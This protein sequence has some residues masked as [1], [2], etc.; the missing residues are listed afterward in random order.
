MSKS[1][2]KKSISFLLA[3]VLSVSA[4]FAVPVTN[5]SAVEIPNYNYTTLK[6]VT[7]NPNGVSHTINVD[8]ESILTVDVATATVHPD[9]RY[10]TTYIQV[11]NYYNTKI[12]DYNIYNRD[13]A[14]EQFK[15]KL[16]KGTYTLKISYSSYSNS[17]ATLA[18]NY[19]VKPV[20]TKIV[21][22]GKKSHIYLDK[23][24]KT[25]LSL[26]KTS[27]VTLY[28]TFPVEADGDTTNL[29]LIV[30][31]S[32]GTKV[33]EEYINAKD[34]LYSKKMEFKKE[35]V[36]AKGKYTVNFQMHSEPLYLNKHPYTST[37]SISTKDLPSNYVPTPK[38]TAKKTKWTDYSCYLTLS[39]ADNAKYDGIEVWRKQNGGS[40]KLLDAENNTYSRKIAFSSY[41]IRGD[42]NYYY[43]R[44]YKNGIGTKIYSK[45]SNVVSMKYL[46]KPKVSLGTSGVNLTFDVS[47]RSQGATG[48]EIWRSTKKNS[49]YKKYATTSKN[50]GF[51][52][53][54]KKEKTAY[55]YKVRAYKKAGSE[56]MYS[57]FTTPTKVMPIGKPN[58]IN[59]YS[60]KKQADIYYGSVKGAKGYEIWRSTKKTSGFKKIKTTNKT[61][62]TNKWLASKKTYY[63]KVRAYKYVG[64]TKVY[65]NYTSVKSVKTR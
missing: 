37:F 4:F 65:S 27:V 35:Y 14:I 5:V 8:K 48:Y 1:I 19:S 38:V 34:E 43:I 22:A 3:M 23:D 50:Y 58:H 11:F 51:T 24:N 57:S 36:L 13:G 7:A 55:Y 54:L 21:N 30:L 62:Y 47:T 53:S 41:Y 60:G 25:T 39:W 44:A 32:S 20:D 42:L 29:N 28:T 52:K 45:N 63:Y 40:Y 46:S 9:S 31:N 49:G 26:S 59:L 17:T 33:Y 64:K 56:T 18:Y 15:F 61:N 16:S 2:F 12:Y 10:T 6:T